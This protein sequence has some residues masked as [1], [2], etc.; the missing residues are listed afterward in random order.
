MAQYNQQDG[1]GQSAPLPS[2][3]PA[4]ASA[5]AG[6]EHTTNPDAISLSNI[7]PLLFST[8]N[9]YLPS[10]SF[11]AP[12]QK[13]RGR[14]GEDGEVLGRPKVAKIDEVED[15][16]KASTGTAAGQP[17]KDFSSEQPVTPMP[18]HG[19]KMSSGRPLNLI[20]A[21][22]SAAASMY[23]SPEST[24]SQAN[25]LFYQPSDTPVRPILKMK[26]KLNAMTQKAS[27]LSQE[28]AG[29]PSPS[30]N[31]QI[32]MGEQQSGHPVIGDNT[33]GQQDN[34]YQYPSVDDNNQ[35]Y[36]FPPS[37]NGQHSG[38]DNQLYDPYGMQQGYD[39]YSGATGD[40]YEV[41]GQ[42]GGQDF[43][44]VM[45]TS[46]DVQAMIAEKVAEVVD[47]MN[48]EIHQIQQEEM[49]NQA[50]QR[51]AD[52]EEYSG[53]LHEKDEALNERD[54]T[55][56]G[57]HA[58]LPDQL[59]A[60][61]ATF[62]SIFQDEYQ[63]KSGEWKA[64]IQQ[65][66]S[67]IQQ[68][69]SAPAVQAPVDIQIDNYIAAEQ[70]KANLPE[71]TESNAQKLNEL[72]ED[73]RAARQIADDLNAEKIALEQSEQKLE[74]RV[75][76]LT[77]SNEELEKKLVDSEKV[78]KQLTTAKE[79]LGEKLVN[80]EDAIKQLSTEKEAAEEKVYVLQKQIN[81]T[82]E[83]HLETEEELNALKSKV[84][85]LEK[86][87]KKIPALTEQLR[88]IEQKV[89][90][91][92]T[93]ANKTNDE[94]KQSKDKVKFLETTANKVPA[95]TKELEESKAKFASLKSATSE[96]VC[97]I[98]VAPKETRTRISQGT[99]TPT[100]TRHQRYKAKKEADDR[101]IKDEMYEA[102]KNALTSANA[103][104]KTKESQMDSVV[105]EISLLT[106]DFRVQTCEMSKIKKTKDLLAKCLM[107]IGIVLYIA[108]MCTPHLLS[109]PVQQTELTQ[110]THT[111]Y[112]PDT[113]LIPN[114]DYHTNIL[115]SMEKFLSKE[116]DTRIAD[117]DDERFIKTA[118]FDGYLR[119]LNLDAP[120]IPLL[121]P[122]TTPQQEEP[123]PIQT[124]TMSTAQTE[125]VDPLP[126]KSLWT[127]TYLLV[128]KCIEALLCLAGIALVL[129]LVVS[130]ADDRQNQANF[131]A[132]MRRQRG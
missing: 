7:D 81:E 70:T 69:A 85:A 66:K 120:L 87:N 27:L 30:E 132:E 86:A 95:I 67:H 38:Y 40:N 26:S 123:A 75:N 78:V 20:L 110:T 114:P 4:S 60:H 111:N 103:N 48:R 130:Y 72:N 83:V 92:E 11:S 34:G 31:G 113:I 24:P 128:W 116:D 91:L 108:G 21:E 59:R 102:Q 93:A 9:P 22:A 115:A 1:F 82:P 117:S 127:F 49:T 106:E 39:A 47:S 62:L 29:Y 94:L 125:P 43:G 118:I 124:C 88:K 35:S 28:T 54:Q 96:H 44:P 80:C 98:L 126:R 105:V 131:V 63:K 23:P 112:P 17:V 77:T 25:P 13:K 53:I 16:N 46:D 15:Q 32:G 107:I 37:W 10:P 100:P 18:N 65:L 58:S 61:E 76:S 109:K 56:K 79:E 5:S 50:N 6:F 129:S 90:L 19:T 71:S 97:P 2:P 57:L 55:I 89:E 64:E 3:L 101:R 45:Y 122:N 33:V 12:G 74:G 68:V 121:T 42:Q 8:P 14:D 119:L 84:K 52:W 36:C 104:L 51:R 73:V 99:Q 41:N